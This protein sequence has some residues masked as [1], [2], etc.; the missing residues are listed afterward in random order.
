MKLPVLLIICFAVLFAY[1]GLSFFAGIGVVFVAFVT[2]LCLGK[3]QARLQKLFM[4]KQDARVNTTNESLNNIKMLKLYSWT[5]IFSK[6]I[7]NKRAEELEIL[8]KRF[9][10]GQVIVT[11]LYFFPQILSAVIFS[12]YIG[13]GHTLDISVAFT[14]M[15]ILNLLQDPLRTL[16][17]FLG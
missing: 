4:K 3:I 6:V 10:Y 9:K 11:S 12:V 1:L 16:P 8:W 7:E 17:M 5:H 15:T 13:T 2:N 14:V